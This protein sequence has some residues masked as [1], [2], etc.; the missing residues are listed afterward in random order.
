ML[1]VVVTL[2]WKVL[3]MV[4]VYKAHYPSTHTW[5]MHAWQ[6]VNGWRTGTKVFPSHETCN[7]NL[8]ICIS[9]VLVFLS[10]FWWSWKCSSRTSGVSYC[11]GVLANKLFVLLTMKAYNVANNTNLLEIS[12]GS[13]QRSKFCFFLLAYTQQ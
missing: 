7:W 3:M 2:I 11:A 12:W 9:C 4:L 1:I 5:V 6:V 13:N 10:S 8:E